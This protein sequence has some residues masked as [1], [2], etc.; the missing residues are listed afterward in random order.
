M[1]DLL[2]IGTS[3]LNAYKRALDV[4][5]HN[6][7]NASTPGFS[8]Q[9]VDFASRVPAGST[10]GA[11]VNADNVRRVVDE[12]V[13]QRLVAD[14]SGSGRLQAFSSAAARVDRLFSDSDIGI[15]GDIDRFFN[16]LSALSADPTSTAVRTEVLGNARDLAQGFQR[17]DGELDRIGGE[18]EQELSLAVTEINRLAADI[19][20]LNERIATAGAGGDTPN[21]LLD[22]RDA[23]VES[24]AE[25]V[26]LRTVKQDGGD[27]NVFA[28]GGQPLV[29]GSEPGRLGV[30][31]DACGAGPELAF[32]SAA[33]RVPV[34]DGVTGGKIAGLLD[35]RESLQRDAGRLGRLAVGLS[36]TINAQHRAGLDR[37]GRLGGD[38]FTP[39]APEVVAASGNGGDAEP[40]AA[41][42]DPGA[43]T[44][45]AYVLRFDG[46][47]ELINRRT[48]ESVSTTG[49]GTA[50]DPLRADGLSIAVRGSPQPGDRFLLRPTHA[51][52]GDIAAAIS[53]PAALA[54]AAPAHVEAGPGNTG[55]TA[56]ELRVIDARDSNLQQPAQIE[57]VAPDSFTVDGSGPFTYDPDAGIDVNGHRITLEGTPAAGDRFDIR[58]NG[59]DSGDNSNA[60]A[61]AGLVS[62]RRLAGGTRSFGDESANLIAEAGDRARQSERQLEAADAIRAQDRARRDAA[63][64]VNLDEEAAN[65]M[66]FQQGFQ[67]A[68]R[69]ISAADEMFQTLISAVGR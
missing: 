40:T 35:F 3:A 29:L 31:D 25:L 4:T 47:Y 9:R 1:S 37:T 2:G 10:V 11:G 38:L 65:L 61:L 27:V 8:R 14:A 26:D 13:G 6:V 69:V 55:S 49:S 57:F 39:A 15:G 30:A 22:K 46:G 58:P 36:E 23:A 5:G 67:A 68:A 28:A 59:A 62:E 51:A 17:L 41:F 18:L 48:G 32:E 12:F 19:A 63:S 42:A 54:A 66:H 44:G 56:A 7:A 24:L 16:G 64:G 53:D 45:D 43:L 34:G 60:A 20:D 50:G 21:D 52:A 33:G